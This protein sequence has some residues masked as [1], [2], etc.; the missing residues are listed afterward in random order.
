MLLILAT[1][2]L[3]VTNTRGTTMVNIALI[4]RSPKGFKIDALSLRNPPK[5]LPKN[6]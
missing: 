1:E 2:L 3:I 6:Y 4:N 5:I